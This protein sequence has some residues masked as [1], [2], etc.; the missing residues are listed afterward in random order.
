MRLSA[1]AILAG[2]VLVVATALSS[3]HR[4][5]LIDSP[6]AR[7]AALL[8]A[9]ACFAAAGALL[10]LPAE[11][12]RGIATWLT[13][14]AVL[15]PQWVGLE[16]A[17]PALRAAA[18]VGP[19]LAAPALATIARLPVATPA[20]LTTLGAGAIFVATYDPFGDPDCFAVCAPNPL[21]F[22]PSPD[23]ATAASIAFAA[24]AAV[25]AVAAIVAAAGTHGMLLAVRLSVAPTTAI[26]A[27]AAA[28]GPHVGFA[29]VDR[30]Q[31]GALLAAA[32]IAAAAGAW[33]ASAPARVRR[34]VRALATDAGAGLEATLRR[35]LDDQRLTVAFPV[36]D[37]RLVD[38]DGRDVSLPPTAP[39]TVI[40]DADGPV[41]V[42]ADAGA[43]L[44]GALSRGALLAIRNEATTARL[45]AEARALAGLR[46]RIVVT[47]DDERHVLERDL[48][49]GA[50][51]HLVALALELGLAAHDH[52][53]SPLG[54]RLAVLADE[55]E[56]ALDEVRLVAHGIYPSI[57][58]DAGLSGA[59]A[60]L[61]RPYGGRVRLDDRLAGVRAPVSAEATLYLAAA[62]AVH[63]TDGPV[64]LRLERRPEGV[65]VIVAGEASELAGL[66]HDEAL[67]DRVGA[68]SG[69]LRSVDERGWTTVEVVVP[70]A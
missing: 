55:V 14:V 70:C 61:V 19:W 31:A 62:E 4:T 6:G 30:A 36:L 47:A 45:R 15:A 16:S 13:G 24:T 63:R 48:H 11:R 52:A 64:Q 49:D 32:A 28:T 54:D 12:R 69:S 23:A 53:G 56:V 60:A 34:A 2:A 1:S 22:A 8:A 20:W 33:S 27:A 67:A 66:A 57:L 42:V 50:Q 26:A 41:A 46:T 5:V 35:A 17:P 58:D 40:T 25:V 29:I 3:G 38:G 43:L 59:V 65:A 44:P 37:G 51:Q 39:R 10:R 9:A 68:L 21:A 18:L 7:A